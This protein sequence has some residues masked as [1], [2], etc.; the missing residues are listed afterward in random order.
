MGGS[1]LL[2]ADVVFLWSDWAFPNEVA[3]L[4]LL[5]KKVIVYEHGFGS[6]FDYEL[7]NRVRIV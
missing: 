7:D 6:A 2:E 3:K 4:H 1:S 5:D